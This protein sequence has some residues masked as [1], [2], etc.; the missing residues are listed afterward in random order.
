[1]LVLLYVYFERAIC[2]LKRKT[3]VEGQLR[4]Y[5]I[6]AQSSIWQV[7]RH[8]RPLEK[9]ELSA[10]FWDL[11]RSDYLLYWYSELPST[12]SIYC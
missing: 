10:S 6:Q 11:E 7:T 9:E 12:L 8:L 2:K 5:G 1:M 4:L 3:Q